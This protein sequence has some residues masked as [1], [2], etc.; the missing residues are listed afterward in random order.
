MF[1]LMVSFRKKS[2]TNLKPCVYGEFFSSSEKQ[3][4]FF[5]LYHFPYV[6]DVDQ[7]CIN[8]VYDVLAVSVGV[9]LFVRRT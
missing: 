1:R 3:V 2:E 6:L 5:L 8:C 9:V 4:I 7:G